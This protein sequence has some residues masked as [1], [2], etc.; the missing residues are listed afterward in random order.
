MTLKERFY[1]YLTIYV[2]HE[3]SSFPNV[4][5]VAMLLNVG[6][7]NVNRCFI[8]KGKLVPKSNILSIFS[9]ALSATNMYHIKLNLYRPG[10]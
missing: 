6:T 9:L 7:I 2:Y 3:K 10:D 4:A 5:S 1:G 8:L